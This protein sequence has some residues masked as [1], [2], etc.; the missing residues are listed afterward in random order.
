MGCEE[1]VAAIMARKPERMD[2][3]ADAKA[4]ADEAI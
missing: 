2:G 3:G 4:S 1:P